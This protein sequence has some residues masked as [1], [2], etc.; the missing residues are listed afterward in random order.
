MRISGY[1]TCPG[2]CVLLRQHD[3]PSKVQDLGF[4]DLGLAVTCAG[5]WERD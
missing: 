4:E 3:P 5:Y 1:T 2:I